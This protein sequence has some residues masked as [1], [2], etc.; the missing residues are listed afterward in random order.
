MLELAPAN[1][2]LDVGFDAAGGQFFASGKAT[3]D[4]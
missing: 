1:E 4:D 3:K 2:G